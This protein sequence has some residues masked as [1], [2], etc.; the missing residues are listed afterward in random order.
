MKNNKVYLLINSQKNSDWKCDP[1]IEVF[2]NYE[3]AV[4][5]YSTALRDLYSSWVE[6]YGDD[7]IGYAG[8]DG[9]DKFVA[10]YITNKEEDDTLPYFEIYDT[11]ECVLNYQKLYIEEK[12]ITEV[13]VPKDPSTGK[14]I[15]K[16][17]TSKK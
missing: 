17:T 11:R 5:A 6:K 4:S 14:T 2:A 13:K 7:N 1:T 10:N 15:K 8:A 12:E 9:F 3:D 16:T